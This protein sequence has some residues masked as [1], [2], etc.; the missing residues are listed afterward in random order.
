[1]QIAIKK[2]A[3]EE[4]EELGVKNWPIWEK[5]KSRFNWHYAEKETCYFL[6][7]EVEIETETGGKINIGKG[8]LVT[9]PK[10]LS[11]TWNIKKDDIDSYYD[12][13]LAKKE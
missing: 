6:E 4:L 7:G 1:M 2:P 13:S 8:D 11:C 3:A 9:F 12:I 10:G 5:E